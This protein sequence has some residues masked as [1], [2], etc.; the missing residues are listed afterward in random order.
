MLAARRTPIASRPKLA[1]IDS[2]RE[3]NKR[4]YDLPAR[5]PPEEGGDDGRGDEEMQEEGPH[6]VEARALQPPDHRG[7]AHVRHE[8][9]EDGIS[10]HNLTTCGGQA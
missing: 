7:A 9:W 8:R 2:G 1:P 3:Q 5:G 4:I 6:R 10:K